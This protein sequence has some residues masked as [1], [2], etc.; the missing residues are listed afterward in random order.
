MKWI[1]PK[2]SIDFCANLQSIDSDVR[3]S[4]IFLQE[5]LFLGE[6]DQVHTVMVH[7]LVLVVCICLLCLKPRSFDSTSRSPP[8]RSSGFKKRVMCKQK[9][10]PQKNDFHHFGLVNLKLFY[11]NTTVSLAALISSRHSKKG[12]INFQVE[13]S[14]TF[15][16]CREWFVFW[17]VPDL[18]KI[19]IYLKA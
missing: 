2:K 19:S 9:D 13:A 11:L 7:C 18:G 16:T 1:H 4:R 14:W 8:K 12:S 15:K 10:H 3:H 17:F 5:C 6:Y